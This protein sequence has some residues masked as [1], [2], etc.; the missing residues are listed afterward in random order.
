MD[1]GVSTGTTHVNVRDVQLR[2]P[3][4][5]RLGKVWIAGLRIAY[6]QMGGTSRKPSVHR[7]WNGKGALVGNLVKKSEQTLQVLTFC[8][9]HIVMSLREEVRGLLLVTGNWH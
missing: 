3:D 5:I 8:P 2:D 9:T 7:F 4:F 1:Q 6:I